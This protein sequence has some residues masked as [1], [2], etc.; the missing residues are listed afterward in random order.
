MFGHLELLVCEFSQFSFHFTISC[1]I[2]VLMRSFISIIEKIVWLFVYLFSLWNCCTM[3]TSQKQRCVWC[4]NKNSVNLLRLKFQSDKCF[5]ETLT[6][7][8]QWFDC[9]YRDKG[10][11]PEIPSNCPQKLVESM[12]M[13]W[14]K[15]PQ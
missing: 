13:C 12:K 7:H 14:K 15:Q 1:D 10:L 9:K 4:W 5:V 8:L 6:T 2:F 11:T 3:R